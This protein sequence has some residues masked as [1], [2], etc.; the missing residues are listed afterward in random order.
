MGSFPPDILI[1]THS[2]FDHSQGTPVLCREA[3]KRNKKITVMASEKAVSNLKD[4]SWNKVLDEKHKFENIPDVEPLKDGQ[5]IDLAGHELKI[6]D[7]SG[8]CADDIAIYNE[9]KKTVFVGDSVGYRVEN[10]LNFPPFMPPFW[11]PDGFNSAVN[12]LKHL[13][14]EKICL[15]HFGCLKNEEARNFP[16]ET[17]KTC[18]TWWNVFVE[19]DKQG[20]LDDAKYLKETLIKEAELVI[21]DLEVTKTSMLMILGIINR[22][23]KIFGKAPIKVA[24]V[25]LETIIGWLTKGYRTYTSGT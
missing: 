5:T 23:R 21:P 3:E 14:C 11:N 4:Q 22:F 10:M 16:D 17:I 25:Q 1:L 20:K 2:H 15:A 7:F 8:H 18:E 13:E 6:I 12:K 19:A 24:E 9:R